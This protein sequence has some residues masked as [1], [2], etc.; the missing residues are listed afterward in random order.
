MIS[1]STVFDALLIP[2]QSSSAFQPRGFLAHAL[3]VPNT[4][5][6]SGYFP[7]GL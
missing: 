3:Q 1:A 2:L 5:V 6:S 4:P 7:I